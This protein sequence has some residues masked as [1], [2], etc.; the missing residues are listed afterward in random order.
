MSH[1]TFELAFGADLNE[2]VV[3]D[4]FATE[5]R[6]WFPILID[7]RLTVTAFD[8]YDVELPIGFARSV[9]SFVF[10]KP[11][12]VASAAAV[13]NRNREWRAQVISEFAF[14]R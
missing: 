10:R 1:H 3:S 13:K 8:A 9:L 6:G 2:I 12:S 11:E 7:D 14:E 4:G 5:Q